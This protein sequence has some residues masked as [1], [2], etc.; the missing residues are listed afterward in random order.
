MDSSSKLTVATGTAAT[1]ETARVE[2]PVVE[3][4]VVEHIGV[5][6]LKDTL[7]VALKYEAKSFTVSNDLAG[8]A[9]FL[10]RLP[11]AGTCVV[12]LEG[13]GG[14]ERDVIAELLQA[15]HRVALVNP[16]Q[17]RD[18]AKGVGHL[19]KTDALDARVLARF[20]QEVKPP[21]LIVPTGPQ[22]ELKQLVERRRQLVDLR[23]AE[24]NRQQ[25]VNS[26][27]TLASIAA[28]LKLLEK[29]IAS[30]EKQIA[31]L[32]QQHDDWQQRSAIIQSHPGVAQVGAS[33]L[34]AD[35]PELG[36]LN[37]QRIT[38]LA[39]LAAYNHDSGKLQGQRTIFGG[40]QDVRCTL[41]MAALSA[42]RYSPVIKAFYKKLVKGSADTPAKPKKVALV[43]CL[44]KILI[45]LN[46]MV[47]T[48]TPWNDR[49]APAASATRGC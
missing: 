14:Y 25:Q 24:S 33:T 20:G 39:G 6:V 22:S 28:V 23:T 47:R 49:L 15:G 3:A 26:K 30:I 42:I 16:R 8:I 17:V 34:I 12:V 48:N 36:Q 46:E 13:S 45:T 41:S 38:A 9:Q 32:I 37:R 11:A 29:Q 43:A 2:T 40:R 27:K 35:L 10:K 7:E 5:D 21:C 31:E 18:Y 1:V 19:A 44:R 4:P